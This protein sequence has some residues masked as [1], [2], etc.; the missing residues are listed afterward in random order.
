[1]KK[2]E[3]WWKNKVDELSNERISLTKRLLMQRSE[4][5]YFTR[6]L[7]LIHQ[8]MRCNEM[9]ID[10]IAKNWARGNNA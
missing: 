10:E 7:V 6:Q 5:D 3:R 2:G 9:R 8:K 4:I 1:M